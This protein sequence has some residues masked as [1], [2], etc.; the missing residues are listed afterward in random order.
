MTRSAVIHSESSKRVQRRGQI[1]GQLGAKFHRLAAG[2]MAESQVVSVE[3]VAGKYGGRL[4]VNRITQQRV[5]HVGEMHPD[6]VG[7]ACLQ[8]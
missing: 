6:L 2:G 4:A 3:E 8:I 5:S 7:S 1:F